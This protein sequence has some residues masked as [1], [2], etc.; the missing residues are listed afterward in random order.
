M[1]L[2]TIS[3]QENERDRGIDKE[4]REEGKRERGGERRERG[5]REEGSIDH[6]FVELND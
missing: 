1:V 4:E 6:V 3:N 2:L 5:G